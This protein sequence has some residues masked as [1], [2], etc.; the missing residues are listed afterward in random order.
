MAGGSFKCIILSPNRLIYEKEVQSIFLTGD[1]GEFEL[2]AYHYPLLGVLRKGNIIVNWNQAIPIEG[3][4]IRFF[5]NECTILIEEELEKI[6]CL[7]LKDATQCKI[8]S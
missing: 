5:A 2:L 6:I 3:G 1:K 4:V 7:S 8:A